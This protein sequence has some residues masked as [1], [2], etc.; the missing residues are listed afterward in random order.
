MYLCPDHGDIL[1]RLEDRHKPLPVWRRPGLLP[2]WL[3]RIDG[4]G[5]CRASPG[6]GAA[7]CGSYLHGL[8]KDRGDVESI[9]EETRAL[10]GAGFT[11]PHYLN[12][13]NDESC[14]RR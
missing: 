10:A 5:G 1:R 8:S 12:F 11:V 2:V 9:Y 14:A 13:S 4:T 3:Y 7:Y 6:C